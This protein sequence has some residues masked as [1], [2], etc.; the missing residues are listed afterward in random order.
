MFLPDYYKKYTCYKPCKNISRIQIIKTLNRQDRVPTTKGRKD[1]HSPHNTTQRTKAR[2]A[3]TLQ[4]LGS[5]AREGQAT[6]SL[7]L[8]SAV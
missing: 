5:G 3:Q 6:P 2:V 4:K 7:L 1:K 8:A